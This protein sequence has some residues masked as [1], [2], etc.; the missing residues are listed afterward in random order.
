MNSQYNIYQYSK[1]K[2]SNNIVFF[3]SDEDYYKNEY[4]FYQNNRPDFVIIF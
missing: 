2:I 3:Y 4:K 1:I